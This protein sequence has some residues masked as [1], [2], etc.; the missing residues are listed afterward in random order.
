MDVY[1]QESYELEGVGVVPLEIYAR[2]KID[3][4]DFIDA[5]KAE[6]GIVLDN[7][8]VRQRLIRII[9]NGPDG[10]LVIYEAKSPGRGAFWVTY[11]DVYR[12]LYPMNPNIKS[13]PWIKKD[14]E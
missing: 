9:P 4:A 7:E 11:V 6:Y 1:L 3:T 12:M 5:Y 14:G 2:G 13:K 8:D 10:E